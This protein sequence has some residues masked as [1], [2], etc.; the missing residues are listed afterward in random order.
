MRTSLVARF[1]VLAVI[2]MLAM[3]SACGSH[4][5]PIALIL[6][7]R[8][9]HNGERADANGHP[10]GDGHVHADGAANAT[11]AATAGAH[12]RW[13]PSWDDPAGTAG[14]TR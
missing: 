4:V 11:A 7:R 8:L 14:G 12:P 2:A 13:Y 10:V 3:V 6:A 9:A 1:G 5:T